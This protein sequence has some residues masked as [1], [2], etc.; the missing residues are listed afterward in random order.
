LID[1]NIDIWYFHSFVFERCFRDANEELGDGSLASW[2]EL[3]KITKLALPIT[4]TSMRP[5]PGDYP[6]VTAL[7]PELKSLKKLIWVGGKDDYRYRGSPLHFFETSFSNTEGYPWTD[8]LW[9]AEWQRVV[10]TTPTFRSNLDPRYATNERLRELIKNVDVEF[11]EIVR[12]HL[13][14]LL[15]KEMNKVIIEVGRRS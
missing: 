9:K 6:L 1:D 5:T 12:E 10:A 8:T 15:S 7:L 11:V 3:A 4:R 2:A 13:P 14:R